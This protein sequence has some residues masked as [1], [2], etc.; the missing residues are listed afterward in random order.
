MVVD[1]QEVAVLVEVDDELANV[2][3]VA[4]RRHDGHVGPVGVGGDD[5]VRVEDFVTGD[6]RVAGVGEHFVAAAGD[7]DVDVGEAAGQGHVL[8]DALEMADEHDLVD[9]GGGES[10]DFGLDE[11]RDVRADD[12]IAGAGDVGEIGGRGADDADVFARRG[13]DGGGCDDAGVDESLEAGLTR[14]VE[15]GRE[16]G[17]RVGDPGDEVGED[18][19]T[20]VEVVVADCHGVV[21]DGVDADGVVVGDPLVE[22]GVQLGSGEEVV[23]RGEGEDAVTLGDRVGAEAVHE[24]LEPG[25]AAVVGKVASGVDELALRIVVVQERE[26]QLGTFRRRIRQGGRWRNKK[27]RQHGDG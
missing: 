4:G 18:V 23:A 3:E 16:E 19:G 13:H 9:T 22:A 12:D 11:G 25:D 10:V 17:G 1:A 6:E 26:R 8:I 27:R 21:A 20:E 15:V 2:L 24:G 7:H 5:R 14:E